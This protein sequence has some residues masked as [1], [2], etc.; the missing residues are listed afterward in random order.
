MFSKKDPTKKPRGPN[1]V[2]AEGHALKPVLW[3]PGNGVAALVESDLEQACG[4]AAQLHPTFAR[5]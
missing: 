1:V 2:L 5:G 3:F 4:S